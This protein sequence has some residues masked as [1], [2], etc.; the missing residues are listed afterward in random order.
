MTVDPRKKL[1]RRRTEL[2]IPE[3]GTVT[4]HTCAGFPCGNFVSPRGEPAVYGLV[5][6][7]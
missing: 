4:S 5:K 6:D 7:T 1:R 2:R 3:S